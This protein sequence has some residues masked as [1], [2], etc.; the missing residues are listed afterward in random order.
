M[1]FDQFDGYDPTW[2]GTFRGMDGIQHIV[3][4]AGFSNG[5]SPQ[6]GPTP[7]LVVGREVFWNI[8]GFGD[9][10]D[11]YPV[12]GFNNGARED[13]RWD[14]YNEFDNAMFE[15]G[16]LTGYGTWVGRPDVI[17]HGTTAAFDTQGQFLTVG[18]ISPGDGIGWF[19]RNNTGDPPLGILRWFTVDGNVAGGVSGWELL[20][21][22]GAGTLTSLLK[23][24]TT[25]GA[26]WGVPVS[27][28][29]GGQVAG[30]FK[31]AVVDFKTPATIPVIPPIGYRIATLAG[32]FAEVKTATAATVAPTL[33]GGTDAGASNIVASQTP[34]AIVT[35]PIET[36]VTIPLLTPLVLGDL[37]AN[38]FNMKITVGATATALTG[39]FYLLAGLMPI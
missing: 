1:V 25:N 5:S 37:S 30:M 9:G 31:S 38:G 8:F 27:S 2:D 23:M 11:Y 3:A 26:V 35:Q 13:I 24:D 15:R 10:P 12:V 17:Q 19:V 7:G 34:A 39:R 18:G 21:S 20:G 36:R 4:Q 28:I 22:N 6:T 32:M 16:R 33:Q 14:L 29:G